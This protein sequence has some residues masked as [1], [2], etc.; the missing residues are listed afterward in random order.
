MI[1]DVE[2][3]PTRISKEVVATETMIERT[4]ER[5][6]LKPKRI[7]GD[8]A[9]GTGP[10]LGCVRPPSRNRGQLLMFSRLALPLVLTILWLWPAS[11][12]AQ[13]QPQLEISDYSMERYIYYLADGDA[14]WAYSMIYPGEA[15]SHLKEAETSFKRALAIAEKL[16]GPEHPEVAL[17]LN[18]L[19]SVYR[20][21]G[22]DAEAE[23]LE[24]RAKTIQS[25]HE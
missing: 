19:A 6:D 25:K 23:R 20:A 18:R 13:D 2:A 22:K 4:E 16:G 24:A 7:A 11:L 1:V 5:F 21:Q 12:H 9:Y 8:V 14:A 10:T 3:T 17:C 15:I